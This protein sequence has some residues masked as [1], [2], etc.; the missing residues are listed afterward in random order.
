MPLPAA[1]LYPTPLLLPRDGLS[2]CTALLLLPLLLG[3]RL[4]GPLLLRLLSGLFTAL[5]PCAP[6]F[7]TALVLLRLRALPLCGW[8]RILAPPILP[9][10]GLAALVVLPVSLRVRWDRRPEKQTQSSGAGS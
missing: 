1:L 7:R 6:L 2:L 9:F 3:P 5:L 8:W 4:L 10:F